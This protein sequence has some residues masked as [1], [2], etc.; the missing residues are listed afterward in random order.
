MKLTLLEHTMSDSYTLPLRPLRLPFLLEGH[1]AIW[2]SRVEKLCAMTDREQMPPSSLPVVNFIPVGWAYCGEDEFDYALIYSP[3][4]LGR[5]LNDDNPEDRMYIMQQVVKEWNR[6]FQEENHT[7]DP[8]PEMDFV[9][10]WDVSCKRWG[11]KA[12]DVYQTWVADQTKTILLE[13]V[14]PKGLQAAAKKI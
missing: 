1:L 6:L 14:A 8:M 13:H 9:Y 4:L 7:T 5:R 3:A 10:A 11:L 12:Q 2:R